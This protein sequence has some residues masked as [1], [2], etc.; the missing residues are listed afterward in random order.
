ME[1]ASQTSSPTFP[2]E[3][4][5]RKIPART[6]PD[7]DVDKSWSLRNLKDT[8]DNVIEQINGAQAV[9]DTFK[10]AFVEAIDRL[11]AK[12]RLIEVN[13]H[14]QSVSLKDGRVKHHGCWD[15]SEL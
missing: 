11:P 10:A 8:R 7:G 2:P 6:M 12:A 1:T 5:P 9:P 15:I 14:S 13:V 3:V 4:S